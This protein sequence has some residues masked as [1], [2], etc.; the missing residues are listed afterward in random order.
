MTQVF[1]RALWHRKYFCITDPLWGESTGHKGSVMRSF[2]VFV[3]VSMNKML[4]KQL[5]GRWFETPWHSSE[6]NVMLCE[7]MWV[8]IIKFNNLLRLNSLCIC[9]Y[10]YE[11]ICVYSCVYVKVCECVFISF[12]YPLSVTRILAA[13]E[14]IMCDCLPWRQ[15]TNSNGLYSLSV[16]SQSRW[17]NRQIWCIKTIQYGASAIDGSFY[18]LSHR[19]DELTYCGLV[20]LCING[21]GNGSVPAVHQVSAYINS[22]LLS[23]WFPGTN[24]I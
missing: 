4:N 1:M 18:D 19:C 6:V 21:S 3:V 15:M 5:S 14:W 24:F 11:C 17:K 9:V 10:Q 8:R 20:N 7:R 16:S 22:E 2:N 23:I 13:I 12:G